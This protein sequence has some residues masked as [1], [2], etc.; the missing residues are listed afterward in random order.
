M[1]WALDMKELLLSFRSCSSDTTIVENG[2][3]PVLEMHPD[4]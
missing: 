1:E 4:I 3:V 2:N